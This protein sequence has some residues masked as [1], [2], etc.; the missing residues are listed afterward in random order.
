MQKINLTVFC[1]SKQNLNSMYYSET[2]KVIRLIS[3]SKYNIVYGGGSIG[4]M[5]VVRSSWLEIGG[6]IIS[7][8]VQK[9]AEPNIVDDYMYDN[10]IDR[11]KK[12]VEIG[13]GYLIFPGG[14]GTNYELLEVITK[15]DVG[16]SFKPIFILN[17]NGIFNN[18]ICHIK[19][20]IEE[21]FIT[22]DFNK[23][24]IFVETEPIKIANRINQ[25]FNF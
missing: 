11:Q 25:F 2:K 15:N 6:K 8:N 9:F 16:E 1:S 19:K 3:P 5:G 21:G 14:Y 13:D 17:T 12:L 18:F 4:I 23:L 7:S 22:K 24:N 10:I 20:L